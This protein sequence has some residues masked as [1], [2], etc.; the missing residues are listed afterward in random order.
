MLF[1]TYWAI[2][3]VINMTD[4]IPGF[5]KNVSYTIGVLYNMLDIPFIL[6]ILFFTSTSILVRRFISISLL[7]FISFEIINAFVSGITYDALKYSLGAGIVL[8]LF[9]LSWEILRYMQ[10]V[11]HSNRQNAKVFIYAALLFEYATFVLIYIFDYFIL[12]SDSKD[13]F[14]IYYISTLVA[15]L[16]A[17]CGY[18]LFTKYERKNNIAY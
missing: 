17:S 9:V 12:S 3:G 13:S 6:A 4:L 18:L 11:E 10:K 8:V 5:P 15:I 16:I 2:G 14:L 7:I 1:A